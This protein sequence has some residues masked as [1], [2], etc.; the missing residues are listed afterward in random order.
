[1][2][3]LVREEL[4]VYTP[5][6]CLLATSP[7]MLSSLTEPVAINSPPLVMMALF[8]AAV[9]FARETDDELP[10]S[11]TQP[12]MAALLLAATMPWILRDWTC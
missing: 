4:L 5:E 10:S 9:M 12:P 1:M 6:L 8:S 2:H 7:L 11:M 3:Q